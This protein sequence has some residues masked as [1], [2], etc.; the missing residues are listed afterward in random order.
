MTYSEDRH[1]DKEFN[2]SLALDA[3][4]SGLLVFQNDMPHKVS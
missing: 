1:A 3:G 4:E 2:M